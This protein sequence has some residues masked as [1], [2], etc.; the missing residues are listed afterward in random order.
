MVLNLLL[1]A[2]CYELHQSVVL[3]AQSCMQADLGTTASKF[4]QGYPVS[5]LPASRLAKPKRHAYAACARQNFDMIVWAACSLPF[6]FVKTRIQKMEKGP[7][8]KFPYKGS[9]DC[10]VQTFTKE[11]PLKFYTG[12]PT[13]CVRCDAAYL[14]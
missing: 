7:D 3:G 6:D 12:F 11:G 9:I 8:G 13:Y 14:P 10:A 4:W 2:L 1:H 5:C